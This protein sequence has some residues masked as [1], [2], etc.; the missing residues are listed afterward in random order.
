MG[1]LERAEAPSLSKTVFYVF[2]VLYPT[3]TT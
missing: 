2:Y 1:G 3:H